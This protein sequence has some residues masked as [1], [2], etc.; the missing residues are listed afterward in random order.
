MQDKK[1]IRDPDWSLPGIEN[2]ASVKQLRER[3]HTLNEA[4]MHLQWAVASLQASLDRIK[5]EVSSERSANE[6]LTNMLEVK[7]DVWDIQSIGV[8]SV[9]KIKK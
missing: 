7:E 9:T 3:V 1:N 2:F 4:V 5:E 6:I 8:K